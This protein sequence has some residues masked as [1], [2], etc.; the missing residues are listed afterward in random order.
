MN[1]S[2][3]LEIDPKI[4]DFIIESMATD[5]KNCWS[6][7]RNLQGAPASTQRERKKQFVI[8]SIIHSNDVERI[9]AN[10]YI[11]FKIHHRKMNV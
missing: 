8:S 4:Y 3:S 10:V 5:I 2:R 6:N 9:N 7:N 1:K 11:F